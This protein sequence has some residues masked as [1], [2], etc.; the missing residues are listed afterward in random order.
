M[1]K[2]FN[3][4]NLE[5]ITKLK[6][7]VRTHTFKNNQEKNKIRHWANQYIQKY[8]K[9][10]KLKG[11]EKND[12][13]PSF[14]D[15]D[16]KS[17]NGFQTSCWGPQIWSYLHFTSFNYC[18]ARSNEYKTLLDGVAG[19]LPCKYCRDN[20]QDNKTKAI[21]DMIQQNQ[22]KKYNDIFKS[23][24]MYS[25]FIYNVHHQVNIRLGKCCDNE[26]SYDETR[27]FYEKFRSRCNEP[28]QQSDNTE[29]GCLDPEYGKKMKCI[30]SYT[31]RSDRDLKDVLPLSQ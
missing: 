20:F 25:R 29:G 19:T 27:D 10:K 16:Y 9:Y 13:R 1:Q 5:D 23:R 8:N 6:K 26:P 14:C 30:I 15:D 22:I 17:K 11:G 31:N 2:T 7:I 18:P 12:W 24:D 21:K 4:K 3:Y 28:K